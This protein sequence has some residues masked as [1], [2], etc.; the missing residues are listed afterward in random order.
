MGVSLEERAP[1]LD[2]HRLVEFAWRLPLRM[3]MRNGQG[4]WLMRQVLY[5]YL[6]RK[7]FE[8]P[9]QGFGVPIDTWLRGPIKGWS[10]ELLGE[11]RLKDEGFFNPEP[12]RQKWQEHLEGKNNWQYHLWDILMFEAWYEKNR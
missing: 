6:P 3:K 10:E 4:K 5:Q 2:D 12:V 11:Q 9:K 7:M 8:R 1:Y